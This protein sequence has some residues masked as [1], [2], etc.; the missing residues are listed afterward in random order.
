M[1]VVKDNLTDG[2]LDVYKVGDFL[3]EGLARKIEFN[4]QLCVNVLRKL[5]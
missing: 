1:L 2:N 3:I 5:V 4:C